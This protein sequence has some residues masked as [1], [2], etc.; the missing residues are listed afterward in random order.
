M[1]CNLSDDGTLLSRNKPDLGLVNH[2]YG[3]LEAFG[4]SLACL[5]KF[6][7]TCQLALGAVL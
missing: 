4:A 7:T 1:A 2:F 6:E 5:S 3:L